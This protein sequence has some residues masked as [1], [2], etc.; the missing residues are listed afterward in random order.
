MAKRSMAVTVRKLEA[1]L[2]RKQ[3]KEAKVRA[4]AALKTKAEGLRKKLRGY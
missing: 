1:K 2:K 3:M 4:K